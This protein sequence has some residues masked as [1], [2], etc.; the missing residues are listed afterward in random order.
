MRFDAVLKKGF[1]MKQAWAIADVASKYFGGTRKE[2]FSESLKMAWGFARKSYLKR[3][4]KGNCHK[5]FAKWWDSLLKARLV[6]EAPAHFKTLG[7]TP[8]ATL[9]EVRGA[10]RKLRIL[11]NPSK[12]GDYREYAKIGNAYQQCMGYLELKAA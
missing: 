1:I 4:P 12:G 11:H 7:L 2:Y 5:L 8:Q 6:N 3:D 9:K 10:N